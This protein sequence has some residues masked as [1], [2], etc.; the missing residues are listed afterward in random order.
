MLLAEKWFYRRLLGKH[1]ADG[2]LNAVMKDALSLWGLLALQVWRAAALTQAVQQ[3]A[4]SWGF[5]SA[6]PAPLSAL[7]KRCI[8]A[9]SLHEGSETASMAS[10]HKEGS[11]VPPHLKQCCLSWKCQKSWKWICFLNTTPPFYTQGRTAAVAIGRPNLCLIKF[12]VISCEGSER[13]RA[14]CWCDC[15]STVLQPEPVTVTLSPCRALCTYSGAGIPEL[16]CIERKLCLWCGQGWRGWILQLDPLGLILPQGSRRIWCWQ[17][18]GDLV[19]RVLQN[20]CCPSKSGREA[21]LLQL[22]FWCWTDVEMMHGCLGCSWSFSKQGVSFPLPCKQQLVVLLPG[23]LGP[24]RLII[25]HDSQLL[26][27]YWLWKV[28]PK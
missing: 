11:C 28:A 12:T 23:V 7:S 15:F 9:T 4:L 18:H 27:N 13:F 14:L 25:H 3:L 16:S 1:K 10:C 17:R 26:Q 24:K 19:W 20:H 6:F 22:Y 8:L 2:F 21:T 5:Y